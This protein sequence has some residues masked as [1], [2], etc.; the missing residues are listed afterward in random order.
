MKCFFKKAAATL[1]TVLSISFIGIHLYAS[2]VKGFTSTIL[3]NGGGDNISTSMEALESIYRFAERN[4]IY[5]IDYDKVY[6]AMAGAMLDAF[7]DEW[8]MY[9]P[10]SS[11]NEYRDHRIGNYGGIGIY[12]TKLPLSKQNA[13]D[14]KTLYIT[15]T[16]VFKDAPSHKAGLKRSDLITHINGE[17]V[18]SKTAGECASMLKGDK[19]ST[20]TL[21]ILRGK[22]T[23]DV[24]LEREEVSVPTVK[25]TILKGNV[26]YIRIYEFTTQ[27][28]LQVSDELDS[29]KDKIQA[30]II[31]MRDNG[32]GDVSA[33]IEIADFFLPSGATIVSTEGKTNEMSRIYLSSAKE[34]KLNEDVPIAVLINSGT[35]S[36][37]ELL[38]GALKENNRAVV[39]GEK[40][41]G[42]GVM[43]VSAPFNNGFVNVT[44]AEYKTPG[45]NTVNKVGITPDEEVKENIGTQEEQHSLL[46]MFKE[47]IFSVYAEKHPTFSPINVDR[48][49][50]EYSDKYDIS[51]ILLKKAITEEYVYKSNTDAISSELLKY[52]DVVNYA[53]T[54]INNSN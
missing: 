22:E 28:A 36:A 6:E 26:G 4:F 15:I 11:S 47:N 43:Q 29:I 30:L 49:A 52:D 5:N 2:G 38:A 44:A 41:Y 54:Y 51:P 45:G 42:K 13:E 39:F 32:G 40:S 33:C 31:D 24:Q 21:S 1:I 34:K 8:T 3:S 23:F 16:N 48:F 46:K 27:T 19:G 35:A 12:L 50:H 20:V 25:S 17:S 18:I 7:G 53:L 10:S 9:I 37:A 14:P